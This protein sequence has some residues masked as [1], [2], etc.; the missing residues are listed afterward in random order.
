MAVYRDFFNYKSGVY[1][2]TSGTLAGYH[3]VCV[4]GYSERDQCWI[5]KNSWGPGWGDA[6]WFKIGYGE[7]EMDTK[8]A[9]YGVEDVTPPSPGPGPEP[10]P[11]GCWKMIKDALGIKS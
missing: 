7:C 10:Q 8:F 11:D 5:V 6:G 4:V 9:M 3:A 1:R 2:H